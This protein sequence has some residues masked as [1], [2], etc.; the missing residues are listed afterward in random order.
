MIPKII[1][2]CWFGD[3]HKSFLVYKC[4]KSW[5]KY[6]PEYQ[7]KE[8][9]ESNVV[10]DNPYLK[11]AHSQK[12][13]SR[14][15]N[16][17]RLRALNDYGGIYLDTDIEIRKSFDPLLNQGCFVGFQIREKHKDW[18]NNAVMG[19]T[20][21]HP[22]LK[23]CMDFMVEECMRDNIF[24]VQPELTTKVLVQMGL[25]EYGEQK[26]GDV[27]LYPVEYFFPYSWQEKFYPDCVKKET[28][29]VHHW[30]NT[31][32]HKLTFKDRLR[33]IWYCYFRK[34]K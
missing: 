9:N 26:I 18:V 24:Y 5:K 17:V 31:W 2:Y 29:C 28:Y 30:Q 32:G 6:M 15:S 12:L 4:R 22:L 16:Y 27:Q 11:E 19:A 23:R 33:K 7:V 20:A 14:L 13:W 1:H 34:R 10:L 21:G 8:W 25:K 3:A